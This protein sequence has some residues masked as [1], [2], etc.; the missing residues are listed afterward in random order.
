MIHDQLA[1]CIHTQL[2]EY[3]H[4][5]LQLASSFGFETS[6][7]AELLSDP[8][9]WTTEWMPYIAIGSSNSALVC[10][11]LVNELYRKRATIFAR[12]NTYF[13]IVTFGQDEPP[14]DDLS[15]Y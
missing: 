13:A 10:G 7:F 8:N 6:N 9:E 12:T 14:A 3:T 1:I 11:A 5:E 4:L 2:A 15:I